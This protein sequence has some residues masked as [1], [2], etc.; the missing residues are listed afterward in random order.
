MSMAWMVFWVGLAIAAN[1][2][3]LF[4]MCAVVVIVIALVGLWIWG[5]VAE[6]AENESK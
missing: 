1:L 5:G 4:A 2:A 6:A 3:I